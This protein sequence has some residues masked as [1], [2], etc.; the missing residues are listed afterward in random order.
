MKRVIY[1]KAIAEDA[2]LQVVCM[3]KVA[4]FLF[5]FSAGGT[6]YFIKFPQVGYTYIHVDNT[7]A[8]TRDTVD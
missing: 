8:S 4:Y 6:M 1:I 3:T 7:L 5:S 2:K